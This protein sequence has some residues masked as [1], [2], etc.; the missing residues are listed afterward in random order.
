MERYIY[1]YLD[2]DGLLQ[3]TADVTEAEE[4]SITTFFQIEVIYE[5]V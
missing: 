1:A 4:F 2:E 5:A 3:W